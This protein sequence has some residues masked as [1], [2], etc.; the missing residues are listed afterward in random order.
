MKKLCTILAALA[1]VAMCIALIPTEAQ[2]ASQ[3]DLTFTLNSD[4]QSYSVSKCNTSAN[5]SLII[6]STYNGKPVTTIGRSAFQACSKLTS[7]T[8]PNVVTSIGSQAFYYCSS[9]TTLTIPES[10]TSLVGDY[11]F[12]GCDKL[13]VVNFNATNMQD[14]S[15]SSYPAFGNVKGFTLNVGPNV[16]KSLRIFFVKVQLQR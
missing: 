14:L 9:L 16:K 1:L 6:P 12:F 7:I 13:E 5:G 3:S 4:G 10:V 2:A 8:I 11:I 15:S